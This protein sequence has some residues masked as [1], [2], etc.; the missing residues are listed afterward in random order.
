MKSQIELIT[1]QLAQDW[2]EAYN[3]NNRPMRSS[4]VR[5]LVGQIES[6]AWQTTHQ[7]IGFSTTGRLLDGQHRLAA[8]AMGS[9]SV[10]CMVTRDMPEETFKVVDSG[11]K[12]QVY[13]RICVHQDQRVNQLICTAI[14]NY[15]RTTV[16]NF[17]GRF[18]ASA[19]DVEREYK[20]HERAWRWVGETFPNA[21]HALRRAPMLSAFGVYHAVHPTLA[22]KMADGYIS[23]ADVAAGS[24]ALRLRNYA[25]NGNFTPRSAYWYAQECMI[26]DSDGTPM[27]PR[28]GM[29]TVDMLGNQNPAREGTSMSHARSRK[30]NIERVRKGEAVP[31][32]AWV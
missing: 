15:L 11:M 19:S 8:I 12:R 6:G 20:T 3:I 26:R 7:G 16:P 5:F 17:R 2:L 18:S 28:G 10:K 9:V 25:L 27:P 29:A 31:V 23:G 32:R 14:S 1:P 13:D 21:F 24:P 4:Q 30:Q 22:A